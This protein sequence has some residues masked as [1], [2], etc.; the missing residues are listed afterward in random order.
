MNN[1][2]YLYTNICGRYWKIPDKN[3]QKVQQQNGVVIICHITYVQL[4]SDPTIWQVIW[5]TLQQS[6]TYHMLC[7]VSCI[8]ITMSV[9]SLYQIAWME[10]RVRVHLV[11][12]WYH[13]HLD[14]SNVSKQVEL[15]I[16]CIF[17]LHI[18]ILYQ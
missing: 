6:H 3:W 12:L 10:C 5:A 14:L 18:V 15:K 2:H 17:I 16:D 9:V 7:L 13:Q 11:V 8:L 1:S 4:M